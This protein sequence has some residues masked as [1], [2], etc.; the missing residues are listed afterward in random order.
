MYSEAEVERIERIE[1][2]HWDEA[3]ERANGVDGDDMW[4]NSDDWTVRRIDELV[5]GSSGDGDDSSNEGDSAGDEVSIL[6][7]VSVAYP[8]FTGR[9]IPF[10]N[11]ATEAGKR[12][13]H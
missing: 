12:N 10:P 3:E 9:N 6:D 13:G 7:S 2:V 1:R 4:G 8:S 11:I 5:G